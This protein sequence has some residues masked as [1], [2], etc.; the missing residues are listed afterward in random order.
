MNS[1]TFN[2]EDQTKLIQKCF[3]MRK[4]GVDGAEDGY[5]GFLYS[6][7]KRSSVRLKLK[8]EKRHREGVQISN[9]SAGKENYFLPCSTTNLLRNTQR[10]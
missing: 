5:C 1:Y 3:I 2:R 8:Y 7:L 9:I 4:S 6:G 10:N